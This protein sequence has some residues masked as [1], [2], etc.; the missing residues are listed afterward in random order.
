MKYGARNKVVAILA[1]ND[2]I[3]RYARNDN[4]WVFGKYKAR[5][6]GFKEI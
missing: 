4:C 6:F 1:T 3:P 5:N 2:E